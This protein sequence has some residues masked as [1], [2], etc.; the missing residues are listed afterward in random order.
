MYR[1]FVVFSGC[2]L[3]ASP[4]WAQSAEDNAR[5]AFES[6]I[7]AYNAG[8]PTVAAAEFRRAYGFRPSTTLFY[9]IGQCEALAKRH[10]LAYEAFERY[11]AEGGDDVPVERRD[12]VIAELNRL[13]NLVGAVRVV[14]PQGAVVR[15]DGEIRGTAPLPG[16]LKIGVG[17]PH[18]VEITW[19][20]QVMHRESVKV[21]RGESVRVTAG[22]VSSTASEKQEASASAEQ[23]SASAVQENPG[24]TP[25]KPVDIDNNH[26]RNRLILAQVTL[27]VS[28]ALLVGGAVFGAM[29]LSY[30]HDLKS[31]C[32]NGVCTN[33][34]DQDKLS[35]RDRFAPLS[36]TL[37]SVGIATAA[38]GVSLWIAHRRGTKSDDRP[39]RVAVFPLVG[40]RQVGLGIQG[41]WGR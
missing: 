9:N 31:S 35:R 10:G 20:G 21:S 34:D 12:E 38:L 19:Q 37:L 27:G 28:G 24:T 7:T 13:E 29:A 1:L 8:K 36:T 17:I 33:S 15:I 22:G 18:E 25:A 40:V 26:H 14:A 11:L 32:E 41:G 3:F 4:G 30:N 23:A 39:G 6:G 5:Q 2:I 16:V